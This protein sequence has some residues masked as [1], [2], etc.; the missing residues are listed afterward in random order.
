[1]LVTTVC[2]V[3][4]LDETFREARRVLRPRGRIVVGL[5][6]RDSPLGRAYLARQATSVFYRPAEFYGVRDIDE[7]LRRAG[8]G[9]L[10]FRQTLFV[11]PEE[12]GPHEPVREGYGE[13]SFVVVS[14]TAG[15]K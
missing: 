5:V 15:G 9:T 13:G 8:F 6:D 4:D 1:M 10:R 7:A 2:F 12:A 3:D 14:A 11:P